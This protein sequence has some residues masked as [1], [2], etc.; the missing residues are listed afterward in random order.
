MVGRL[1]ENQGDDDRET[2]TVRLS[3]RLYATLLGRLY[4]TLLVWLYATLLVW[5]YA[6]LILSHRDTDS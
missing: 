2:D 3:G 6:T 4:A 1:F 5:L